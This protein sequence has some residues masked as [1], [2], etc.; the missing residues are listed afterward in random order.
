MTVE[1]AE[2]VDKLLVRFDDR[3]ADLDDPV[4]VVSGG[5]E[6][7]SGEVSRTIAVLAKTLAGRGDAGLVFDGE[8]EVVLSK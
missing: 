8:V 3:F 4:K 7:F 5:K 1:K 2:K 6:L